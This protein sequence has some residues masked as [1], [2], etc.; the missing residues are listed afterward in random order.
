VAKTSDDMKV[1]LYARISKALDQ[2]PENQ[3]LELRKV[4]VAKEYIVDGEYVDEIS[5]RDTRPQK[6]EVLRKIRLGLLD[7]V[8]FWDFSRWGRTMSELALDI[9][10]FYESKKVMVSLKEGFDLSTPSGRLVARCL[11]AFANFERDMN[12]ERTMLGLARARAQ[13]KRLGRPPKKRGA[14]KGTLSTESGAK[15][16]ESSD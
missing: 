8:V 1:A 11:A 13:G 3:L 4:A 16:V 14:V 5:S 15:I 2:T 10:E 12:H 6:E 9:E 7:G